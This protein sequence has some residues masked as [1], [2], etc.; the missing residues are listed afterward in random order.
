MTYVILNLFSCT[1]GKKKVSFFCTKNIKRTFFFNKR[2]QQQG[3]KWISTLSINRFLRKINSKE[4][5]T[6][7][8]V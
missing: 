2:Q 7:R 6:Y 1:Q 3:T 4:I 8:K 5:Y